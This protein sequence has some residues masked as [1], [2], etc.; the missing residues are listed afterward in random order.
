MYRDHREVVLAALEVARR[1]E[2]RLGCPACVGPVEEVG[3][4]GKETALRV[5]EHLGSG[6]ALVPA[7]L[8][9]TS[10]PDPA[11]EAEA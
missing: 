4:L 10:D 7:A 11:P 3:A 6:P 5:L 2:C 9:A 1:C 8:P